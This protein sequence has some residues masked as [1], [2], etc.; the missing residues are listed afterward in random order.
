MLERLRTSPLFLASWARWR[1]RQF[2][3]EYERRRERYAHEAERRGLTYNDA[4]VAGLVRNH[5]AG[6]G[7]SPL[8]RVVGA[9]HT[10]A[11]VPLIG[12]HEHLIP[13][14][15]ELGPLSLF[16][17]ASLGYRWDEFARADRDAIARRERM[18]DA[19]WQFVDKSHAERPVDWIFVYASGLEVSAGVL[20]RIRDELGIPVVTMCLDDKNSWE[21]A[22]MGD[23]RAGMIDIA[24]EVDLAWTSARV[25]CEWYLVE[26]GRPVYLP[27]GF[28]AGTFH[29]MPV[30]VDIPASFVGA[31][32][33]YR[34][35]VLAH[36]RRHG[37]PLRVF[38][39][40]WPDGE[41]ARDPIEIYNRSRI[42]VGI[43]EIGYSDVL[44]NVKGRDFEVPATGGGAYLTSY[45]SDLAQHFIVGREILCYR[46][47]DELL[48]Q[49]R[50]SLGR[51]DETRAIAD[52]ARARSLRE[53]RWLHRYQR[54]TDLLGITA[55]TAPRPAAS[56]Q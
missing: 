40:G 16:D 2:H 15:K 37:I 45:N 13:D 26:G 35:A 50:H 49:L 6:R 44:T 8:P 46:G 23:H 42:N 39:R 32:Y 3:Q 24:R 4:A 52:R 28:N 22:P 48:E 21:G 47:P 54:I 11:F 7:Y 19:F 5:Q 38:G 10:L 20:R 14:L 33:G 29:P 53:H 51:P 36:V 18:N 56:G 55:D 1:Q 25:A 31:A 41:F 17:Y 34:P 27:E 9:I 12:W 43:G 30:E